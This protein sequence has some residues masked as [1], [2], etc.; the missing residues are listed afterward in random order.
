MKHHEWQEL[1]GSIEI[2]VDWFVCGAN[3]DVEEPYIEISDKDCSSTIRL[4]F[5][6]PIAYYLT[7]HWC[8]SDCMHELIVDRARRELQNNIKDALG[9]E[10]N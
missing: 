7:T 3:F 6:K 10:E 4:P 9:I 1:G 2:P 5:P 8:G